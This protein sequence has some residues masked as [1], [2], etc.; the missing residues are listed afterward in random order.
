MRRYAS[1]VYAVVM[2]PSVCHTPRLNLGSCKQRRMIDSPGTH[3]SG[4]TDSRRNYNWSRPTGAPNK[5]V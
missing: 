3:F 1:A 5:G 4:A 2:C